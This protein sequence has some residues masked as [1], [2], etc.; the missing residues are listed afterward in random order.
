MSTNREVGRRGF[1]AG[2]AAF[3]AAAGAIPRRGAATEP[4]S[5]AAAVEQAHQEMQRRFFDKH[6]VMLDFTELDG[7]VIIPTPEEC[8]QGKPN[9]LGW[10]SPIENGAMFNGYYLDAAVGRWKR[11]QAEADAAKARRLAEG[12]LFLAS[13]S[14]VPGFVGRGAAT[15]GRSH[16]PM[17]SNDQTF[18][19]F[20][21]L[22]R[23]L[24]DG[25]ATAAERQRI[26]A[27]ITEVGEVV[28][29]HGWKMPAEPPFNFRGG[30]AAHTFESAPRLLFVAKVMHAIGGGPKWEK[31]FVEALAARGGE[32]DATRLDRCE[33]GM[34]FEHGGKHSWTSCGSVVAI[35]G[36]WEM[37]TDPAARARYARGLQASAGLAMESLPLAEK[38]DSQDGTRFEPDWRKMNAAWKP[39]QT[40]VEAQELAIAQLKEFGRIST[41]RGKETNFVREPVFAAWIVTLAPDAAVLRERAPAVEKVLA[42]YD[43]TKLYYSQ[44]FPVESAWERLVAAQA[45]TPANR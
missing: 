27:K 37:E 25:P 29:K 28:Y 1:I 14:D 12:L 19:W 30:F 34:V 16:Y 22:W 3:L 36:L 23:Y 18:P 39:Q 13:M 20:Y 5:A 33:R 11:T 43:Y 2:S 41:R 32:G 44:F 7:S 8:K 40:E 4:R 6:G 42:R 9:A 15:D 24:V 26:V 35:R 17:G 10:W 38:F 21:G 31:I 45:A